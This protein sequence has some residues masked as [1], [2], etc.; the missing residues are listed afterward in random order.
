MPF[1]TRKLSKHGK[2]VLGTRKHTAIVRVAN[3]IEI[4]PEYWS[5]G[6]RTQTWLLHLNTYAMAHASACDLKVVTNPFEDNGKYETLPLS[7]HL[8]AVELGTFR[9]KE[10]TPIIT[11]VDETLVSDFFKD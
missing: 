3:S 4:K 2:T 1:T 5:G 7:N 9:G 10:A 8:A 11:V 6:S